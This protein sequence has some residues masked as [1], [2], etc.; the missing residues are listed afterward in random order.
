MST[1]RMDIICESFVLTKES[2][3]LDRS[4]KAS[5]P[6]AFQTPHSQPAHAW[7]G[8]LLGYIAHL[9][10]LLTLTSGDLL[11]FFF[12][13]FSCLHF[14]VRYRISSSQNRD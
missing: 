14:V 3:C 5:F 12:L 6:T 10:S 7:M 13:F 4:F 9:A 11:P 2:V 1:L 8:R